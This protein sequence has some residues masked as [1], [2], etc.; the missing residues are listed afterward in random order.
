M[1]A[2][3]HRAAENIAAPVRDAPRD[4]SR[5]GYG[6]PAVKLSLWSFA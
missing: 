1:P 4:A 3:A 2:P 6:G 5:R